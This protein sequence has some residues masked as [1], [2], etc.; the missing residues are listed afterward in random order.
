MYRH[1]LDASSTPKDSCGCCEGSGRVPPWLQGGASVRLQA[2][3]TH[4]APHPH[5]SRPHLV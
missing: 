1:M 2:N 3:I 4:E 5:P